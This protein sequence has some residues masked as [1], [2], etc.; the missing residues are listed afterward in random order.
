MKKSHFVLSPHTRAALAE[1]F[2]TDFDTLQN[3][4]P[5]QAQTM[6]EQKLGHPVRYDRSPRIDACRPG[7]TLAEVDTALD[8]IIADREM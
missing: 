6:V 4:D 5:E 1:S 7:R 3:M 8:Q 2:G